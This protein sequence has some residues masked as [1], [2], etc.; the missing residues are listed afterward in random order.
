MTRYLLSACILGILLSPLQARAGAGWTEQVEVVELVPTGLFYY[1]VRL[2][3][4]GNSSGCREKEWYYLL[5]ETPGADKMFDL[6]VESM[7]SGLRLK[8]YV[9]GLCNLQGY[10]E[11]TAVSASPADGRKTRGQ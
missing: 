7:K 2:R 6:F 4:D 1:E 8:V 10:S 5:Y 11:I 3:G 9:N